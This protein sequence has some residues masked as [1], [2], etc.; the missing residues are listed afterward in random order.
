L[1]RIDTITVDTSNIDVTKRLIKHSGKV[2]SDFI[3][4]NLTVAPETGKI[5]SYDK[6]PVIANDS[7]HIDGR[8]IHAKQPT[9]NSTFS[10]I[11]WSDI[12]HRFEPVKVKKKK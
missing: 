5:F 12:I 1:Q 4:K 7:W 8:F 10:E 2:I 11:I 9:R 6:L 3:S